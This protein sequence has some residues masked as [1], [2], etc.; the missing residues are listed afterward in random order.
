MIFWRTC[1]KNYLVNRV[2]IFLFCFFLISNIKG[3]TEQDLSKLIGQAIWSSLP[4]QS[5]DFVSAFIKGMQE[6]DPSFTSE[7]LLKDYNQDIEAKNNLSLKEQLLEADAF[8]KVLALRKDLQEVIPDKVYFQIKK[9]GKGRTISGLDCNVN[10]SY[11]ITMLDDTLLCDKDILRLNIFHLL[12]V[13]S[14]L[15]DKKLL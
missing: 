8:F 1:L 15:Q 11:R 4:D 6:F 9:E 10:A 7:E 3:N 2:C 5:S 14:V 12:L 13:L